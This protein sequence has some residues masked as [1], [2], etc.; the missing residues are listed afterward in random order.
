[1]IDAYFYARTNEA[2]RRQIRHLEKTA[3]LNRPKR[4]KR[5]QRPKRGDGR[6]EDQS[7]DNSSNVNRGRPDDDEQEWNRNQILADEEYLLL[8]SPLLDGFSLSEKRWSEL[9]RT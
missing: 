9:T 1:M 4:P 8:M 6:E 5:P 7:E 2:R 3:L